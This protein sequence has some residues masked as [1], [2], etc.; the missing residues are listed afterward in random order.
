MELNHI[1]FELEQKNYEKVRKLFKEL[2]YQLVISSVIDGSEPALVWVDNKEKPQASFMATNEGYFLAGDPTMESFNH[3]LS[4]LIQG[5]IEKGEAPFIDAGY[6]YFNM[7][8]EKWK[9]Q[10]HIIFNNRV[11]FVVNR[12]HFTCARTE[13]D[14]KSKIPDEYSI[15]SADNTLDI[16]SLNFPDDLWD[17]VGDN[18]ESLISRG[19]GCCLLHGN[20]V[21]SWALADCASGDSCEIGIFT[22][23][24]YRMKGLATL[25]VAATIDRCNELGFSQIGWH[26]EDHNYG[27][28][29]VAKKSGFEIERDYIQC[30]FM[31]DYAEHLA[32]I[33][34]RHFWN[35]E[36][37]LAQ[38]TFN[39]A[40]EEGEVPVWS[41]YLAARANAQLGEHERTLELLSV[42]AE[43]GWSNFEHPIQCDE[44]RVFFETDKWDD[45]IEKFKQNSGVS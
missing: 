38:D 13:L 39:H 11:P 15:H 36:Y 31:W 9:T 10:F 41:Y 6:F 35:Q 42:A 21:L 44:F 45:I 5:F 4:N 24:D 19:F 17:W 23:E 40:F 26:C 2:D 29:S 37:K 27:S 34:M 22:S 33:G 43:H 14:W 12:I 28:I 32:E 25:T 7:Y 16:T 1:V 30:T 8:P 20:R 18:I 3:G